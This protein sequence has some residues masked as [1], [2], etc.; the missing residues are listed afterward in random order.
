M[1]SA[2]MFGKPSEKAVKLAAAMEILHITS[3]VHDDIVDESNVRHG[4]RTLNALE[5][6]KLAVLTGD[7]L[8]SQVLRLCSETGDIAVVDDIAQ[9]AQNM[10]EG[11]LMQQ[12]VSQKQSAE[13]AEYY[14]IIEKR[15]R[16]SC[17][18]AAVWELTAT[19]LQSNSSDN[20]PNSDLPSA[21][22]SR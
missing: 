10:G 14:A 4:R 18:S 7:Y 5:G 8:F 19:A 13:M 17:R 22:R 16:C 3:L 9:L 11:E 12:Y 6:N 2:G 21:W 20:L 1:L 15:R